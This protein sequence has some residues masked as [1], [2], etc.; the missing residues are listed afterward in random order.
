MLSGDGSQSDAICQITADMLNRPVHR[1]QTYE[2]SGLGAAVA[3]FV[4]LNVYDT[5]E[6]A[7]KEM[8]HYKDVFQP[9]EK[10]FEIYS[11]LYNRVYKKMYSSLRTIYK[12]IREITN[13]AS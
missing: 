13:Y 12:K 1:V 3:G 6:I 10:N 8:V 7:V 4:D 5:F 2:T 9:N 11:K